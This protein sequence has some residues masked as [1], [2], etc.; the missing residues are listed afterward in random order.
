VSARL[1]ELLA[2]VRAQGQAEIGELAG[3]AGVSVETTRRDV[4]WLEARGMVRRVYGRVFPVDSSVF[5]SGL[6]ERSG[7]DV[8][9]KRRIATEAV[10]RLGEAQTIFVDEGFSPL[11]F[12]RAL[13]S[14]QA[15]TVVT[16]SLPA[17][18]AL[19]TRT[20]TEVIVLGGRVRG[21]TMGV[22]EGWT[23]TMM[24]T[25]HLDL[26]VIGA[27]GVAVDAG[28][29]TPD[30]V[31]AAV[32]SAA[33]AA[34]RRRVFVGAHHKF[35]VTS[36]VQFAGLTDFEAVITGREL[37]AARAERFIEAGAVIVRA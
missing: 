4:R 31:V 10:R 33:M 19:A 13:P 1:G 27:N 11:L 32:K 37:S 2:T 25:F 9:E 12:A 36:F 20:E 21:R 22:V 26:A 8:E 24:G 6:K 5:E 14:G 29:T 17:A 15:F 35:G 16:S 7:R 18:S 28:M 3:F 34:S 30:P 23:Q